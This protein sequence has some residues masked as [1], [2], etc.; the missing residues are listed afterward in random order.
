MVQINQDIT[1][2]TNKAPHLNWENNK[3]LKIVLNKHQ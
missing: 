3:Y 1:R 2:Y